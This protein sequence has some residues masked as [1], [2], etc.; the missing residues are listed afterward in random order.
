[1]VYIN[2]SEGKCCKTLFSHASE[3][4]AVL[5]NEKVTNAEC[6]RDESSTVHLQIMNQIIQ[7]LILATFCYGSQNLR[8]LWIFWKHSWL[9]SFDMPEMFSV[10]QSR[11]FIF[12]I[13]QFSFHSSVF[14]PHAQFFSGIGS[15]SIATPNQDKVLNE[16]E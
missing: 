9:K 4:S 5:W 1:M 10:V 6:H 7:I 16:D 13:S 11:F 2:T 12:Q 8:M 15:I 14:L 3:N